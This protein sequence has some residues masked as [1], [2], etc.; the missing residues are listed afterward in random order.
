MKYLTVFT[1]ALSSMMSLAQIPFPE[2]IN[3]Y[4]LLELEGEYTVSYTDEVISSSDVQ[5]ERVH[6][7]EVFTP[8]HDH[9]FYIL[10]LMPF[11]AG[12]FK[13]VDGFLLKFEDEILVTSSFYSTTENS[14]FTFYGWFRDKQTW[15]DLE[16]LDYPVSYLA[17]YA[18]STVE[19]PFETWDY[20][21]MSNTDSYLYGSGL[22]EGTQLACA[23]APLNNFFKFQHGDGA[24]NNNLNY[25]FG[26][27]L[28]ASG[29]LM[30]DG[31][32]ILAENFETAGGFE[33]DT[34]PV[35][36]DVV[37]RHYTI[38]DSEGNVTQQS[39]YQVISFE[40]ISVACR[41]DYNS[42]GVVD[43]DDLT[44]LLTDFG[45]GICPDTDLGNDGGV[46]ST[47]LSAFLSVFGTSCAC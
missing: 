46:S 23:H 10:Q 20:Y 26:G 16:N 2:L 17:D 12:D 28:T 24:N 4:D 38:E 19:V 35:S 42:N 25:G 18:N 43:V 22:V 44:K 1:F 33:L 39:V 5:I 30:Y 32:E 3:T 36:G 29:N 41:A 6:S 31:E 40:P 27:W 45:C 21:H 37:L 9:A 15:E 8:G 14:S 47:D 7:P 11:Y 34:E 13:V